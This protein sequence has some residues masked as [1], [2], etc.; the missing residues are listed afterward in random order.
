MVAALTP[1]SGL[2][3]VYDFFFKGNDEDFKKKCRMYH[4]NSLD[5]PH[6]DKTWTKGLT[7]E[8]FR[9]RVLGSFEAPTGLVYREFS[10]SKNVI[11]HMDPRELQG[12]RFYRGLD[13]G[14]SHPTGVVFLAVDEDENFYVWDEIY[15]SNLLIKDLHA[16]ILK[17]SNGYHFIRNVADSA[18]KRERTELKA[19]GFDTIPADKHS[20]GENEMSNRRWTIMLLNQLLHDGKLFVSDRCKNLINEFE[21]HY[22]KDGNRDGEVIKTED[23]LLDSLRYVIS[24]VKRK[25]KDFVTDGERKFKKKYSETVNGIRLIKSDSVS[26][27]V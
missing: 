6:T 3:R 10:R 16:K 20:K 26:V 22:Y 1:L 7:E 8:E 18:A 27:T 13:F 19:L 4:V 25:P 11:P 2:T 17:K 5:N 21:S 9:L 14:V 23:D 15:E 12:A 24:N